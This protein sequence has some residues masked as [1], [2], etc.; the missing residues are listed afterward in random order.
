VVTRTVNGSAVVTTA[1]GLQVAAAS[2]VT[3]GSTGGVP[4]VTVGLGGVLGAAVLG[5]VVGL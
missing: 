1:F 2:A 4:M 3:T 5:V